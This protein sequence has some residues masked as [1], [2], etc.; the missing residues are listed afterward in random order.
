MQGCTKHATSLCIFTL[1]GDNFQDPSSRGVASDHCTSKN[2]A[3]EQSTQQL[4]LLAEA[5]PLLII[6]KDTYLCSGVTVS[7]LV[8][9]HRACLRACPLAVGTGLGAGPPLTHQPGCGGAGGCVAG[10]AECCIG[11]ASCGCP[12]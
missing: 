10:P 8:T 11:A 3:V 1:S 7:V 12:T 9:R 4:S 2:P 5:Q 6:A